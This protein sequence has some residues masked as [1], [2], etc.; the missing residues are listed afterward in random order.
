MMKRNWLQISL[1][2]LCFLVAALYIGRLFATS[3]PLYANVL[4]APTMLKIGGVTKLAALLVAALYAFRSA[5]LLGH[6]NEARLPWLLLATG[7]TAYALGQVTLLYFQL[8]TGTSP[9]PSVAD[10]AYVVSYPLL[11]ASVVAFIRAY[12]RAGFPMDRTPTMWIILIAAAAIVAWPLLRPIIRSADDA[13][14]K[15]LNIAYF[16]FDL[17]LL[18]PAIALLRITSRFRGGAVW[19]IWFALLTGFIFSAAGDLMFGYFSSVGLAAIDP[20]VH[21][22]YVIA[23]AALATGTMVQE[24]LLAT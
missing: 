2:V 1:L 6:G 17:L 22:V 9:F 11:I 3:S 7:L 5:R 24:R 19:Q 14:S 13:L 23:Y 12:A 21:A 20:A 15:S 4:T 10:I 18:I 16:A 8:K